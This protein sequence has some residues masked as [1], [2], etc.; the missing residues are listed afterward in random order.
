MAV[1]TDSQKTGI[2]GGSEIASRYKFFIPGSQF[3]GS[4]NAKDLSGNNAD[5]VI[6]SGTSDAAVWANKGYMTSAAGANGGLYVAAAKSSFDLS[7][8]S[9]IIAGVVNI[10]SGAS[11]VFF[12]GNGDGSNQGIYLAGDVNGKLVAFVSTSD[13]MA[14]SLGAS[15]AVIR[16]GTDHA[17]VVALDSVTKS[18]YYYVDG[19]LSDQA[20]NAFTGSTTIATN[21]YVGAVA[22]GTAVAAKFNG[23]HMFTMSGGLP[24]NINLLAAK[25]AASPKSWF[26]E[27]DFL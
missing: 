18:A 24:S 16:D 25:H 10:A 6:D 17:V 1:T 27:G 12:A 22:G 11:S 4:G 7:T 23:L 3:A 21:F 2:T 14:T 19:T 8:H 9:L 15:T 5:A 26:T 13:A 20:A